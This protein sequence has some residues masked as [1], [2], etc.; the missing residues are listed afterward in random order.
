MA[1][2][3]PED[4]VPQ[5]PPPLEGDRKDEV[6]ACFK[7]FD[8]DGTGM[9]P[10]AKVYAATTNVGPKQMKLLGTLADMDF[11]GDG[12]V[13]EDEWMLYF[14]MISDELS[15]AQFAD[16]FNDIKGSVE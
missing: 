11:N 12:H 14:A 10:I 7:T 8:I 5:G 16:T 4:E 3:E 13:E 9:V 15:D 2:E 6:L 1:D